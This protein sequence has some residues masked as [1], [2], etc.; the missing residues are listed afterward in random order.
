MKFAVLRFPGSNCDQDAYF[1]ALNVLRQPVEYVWHE[2]TDL[3]GADCVIIPGGFSYGD[4]L[5]CGAVAALSPVMGAVRKFA[6][7]GGLVIGICNGFQILCES[8][9]LP[10]VLL[11]NRGLRFICR[12]VHLRLENADTP[13]T[14]SGTMGEVLSIPIAH[15][16][17]NYFADESTLR[18]LEDS[19]RVILRY[20]GPGGEVEDRYNPN[21]AARNI[22]GIVN[23]E[24][25]VAGMM[26]HP[27]RACEPILGSEDGL[28]ILNSI[29]GGRA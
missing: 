28:V 5:R 17:G 13:F 21:G 3:A 2:S 24:G 20:C 27:E 9:L 19:G 23:C 22:A 1:A 8:G 6:A 26:P 29:L 25:N 14:R 12:H 15:G 10:G 16:E 18:E 4:Y 7:S 11:R